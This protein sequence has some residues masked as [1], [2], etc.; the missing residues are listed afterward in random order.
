M[1]H[2][3]PVPLVQRQCLFLGELGAFVEVPGESAKLRELRN[4]HS[5]N[6]F[7][8][9]IPGSRICPESGIHRGVSADRY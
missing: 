8:L 9:G 1:L 3:P 5:A 2:V 7:G 4:L 6:G